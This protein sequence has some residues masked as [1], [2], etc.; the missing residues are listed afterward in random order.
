MGIF[1]EDDSPTC[2]HWNLEASFWVVGVSKLIQKEVSPSQL[3]FP[4]PRRWAHTF[5]N[6]RQQKGGESILTETTEVMSVQCHATGHALRA[7]ILKTQLH[8]CS[9]KSLFFFSHSLSSEGSTIDLTMKGRSIYVCLLLAKET[10]CINLF[11][12]KKPGKQSLVD[13]LAAPQSKQY[14]KNHISTISLKFKLYPAPGV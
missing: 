11:H 4:A 10:L 8:Q 5:L 14:P 9:G 6:Y 2:F 3:T 13:N 12:T 1:L 7:T